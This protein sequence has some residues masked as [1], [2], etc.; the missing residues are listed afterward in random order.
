VSSAEADRDPADW[1]V[2]GDQE[3]SRMGRIS[4]GLWIVGGIVGIVGAFLPGASHLGLPWVLGLSVLV[5]AYGVGSVTGLI[6]WDRASLEALAIGMVVTIPVV[7]L[8][9]YLTGGS[10]SY[11]EP[12]LVCS[13]LYA[14]FFFPPSWAWP[15]MIELLLVAG[16]PLLYDDRAL[17]NA[18][19]PRYLALSA[20]FLAVTGVMLRV[21]RRLVE[22][23][24]SQREIANQDALTGIPNRRAFDRALRRELAERTGSSDGL[25][26]PGVEP[27]ALLILDLDDFKSI[28]DVHGHQIGDAVLRDAAERMG[29]VLRAGDIL[30]RIGGDEFAVIVPGSDAADARLLAERAGAAVAAREPGS[31]MPAPRASVGWAVFPEDGESYETL[32][33]SADDRLLALKHGA[34]WAAPGPN[35]GRK[36]LNPVA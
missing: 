3:R 25:R 21:K 15:V 19:L 24:H 34:G 9:L 26:R 35:T 23:E 2:E 22:A 32:M 4:G 8:A 20:G 17:D 11:I 36:P 14:A 5:L 27:F 29:G 7:G 28:N 12:L 18:Y 33:R 6:P 13:L 1:L 10:I 31:R 16:T 30:A